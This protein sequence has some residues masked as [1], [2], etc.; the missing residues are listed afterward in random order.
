MMTDGFEIGIDNRGSPLLES[1]GCL[2]YI[3]ITVIMERIEYFDR[4]EGQFKKLKDSPC[5]AIYYYSLSSRKAH[6]WN[7]QLIFADLKGYNNQIEYTFQEFIPFHQREK[8]SEYEDTSKTCLLY[9]SPSPRD[10]LLSRMPSS[11]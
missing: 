5:V 1:Y 6:K 7:H 10:G 3:N 9:T 8:I 4:L 11:A 2:E